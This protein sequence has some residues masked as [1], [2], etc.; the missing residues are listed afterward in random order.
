MTGT[1]AGSYPH[2]GIFRGQRQASA[3]EEENVEPVGKA[4][5][6]V[7]GPRLAHQRTRDSWFTFGT[8]ASWPTN[9]PGVSDHPPGG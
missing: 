4:S 8:I 2:R 5:C 7:H 1:T 6:L 9:V 3:R